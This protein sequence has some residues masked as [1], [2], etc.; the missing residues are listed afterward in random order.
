MP[1]KPINT[2]RLAEPEPFV[3]TKEA[4]LIL[5]VSISTVQKMV[6]AGTIRAWRT[7][8]GHRRLSLESLKEAANRLNVSGGGAAG[9]TGERGPR[10]GSLRALVV[11][12]NPVATKAMSKTL[13]AYEGRLQVDY[14][15]DAAEALLRCSEVE[16][17]LVITD[18]V[19]EPFDGFHLIRVLRNSPRF[20]RM[21][22]LVVTGL[23]AKDIEA[24]GGL[25]EDVIV[26]RKPLSGERLSGF[27]DAFVSRGHQ[28]G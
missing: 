2:A 9:V 4:A 12:D 8:G 14:A 7:E 22:I 5:G 13:S 28:K 24:R 27:L 15:R 6:D 26:Y 20:A 21:T 10:E 19:M 3:G 18:L 11:E 25:G 23:S 16:P 1:R 17:D